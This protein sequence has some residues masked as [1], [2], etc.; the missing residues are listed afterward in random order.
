MP[1]AQYKF[2]KGLVPLQV[3]E[4]LNLTQPTAKCCCNVSQNELDYVEIRKHI[5]F[6]SSLIYYMNLSGVYLKNV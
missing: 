2:S 1:S 4:L 3:C 6:S 5:P